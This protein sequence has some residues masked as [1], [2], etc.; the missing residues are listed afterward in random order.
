MMQ[1]ERW[2][3]CARCYGN[4]C[5]DCKMT[6]RIETKEGREDREAYEDSAYDRWKDDKINLDD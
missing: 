2:T 3:D 6:G 5:I 4:G 1:I